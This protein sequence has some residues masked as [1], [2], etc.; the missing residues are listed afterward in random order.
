MANDGLRQLVRATHSGSPEA[1]RLLTRILQSALCQFADLEARQGT[2]FDSLKQDAVAWPRLEY[3]KNGGPFGDGHELAFAY[4]TRA[5]SAEADIARFLCFFIVQNRESATLAPLIMGGESMTKDKISRWKIAA[6]KSKMLPPLTKANAKKW[7]DVASGIF[8]LCYGV[9]FEKNSA[10][11]QAK[12]NGEAQGK[13]PGEIRSEIKKSVK[14]AFA[15]IAPK[16]M[17]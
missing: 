10:F 11:R 9:Q 16:I 6:K 4:D 15:S 1:A 13:A 12:K 3:G 5:K 14:Q 7:W 8:D 17:G 2:L